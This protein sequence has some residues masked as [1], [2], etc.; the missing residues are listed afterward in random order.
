MRIDRVVVNSSPLITLFNS[1]HAE[2]LPGLFSEVHVPDA[3]WLEVAE[4]GHQDIA[5]Q[6]IRSAQWI[7]RLPPT[8]PDPLVMAWDA[9]LGETAVIS[10][11]RT[12]PDLRAIVD[13]DYA[14][15]CARALGVKTLGTCGVI[16]L[17]KHRHLIPCVK[18][19]LDA[20][21]ITGLWL[22]DG[23]VRTILTEAG[24]I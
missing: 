6:A 8:L 17:A 10:L 13:D 1:G 20:L 21:R 7:K 12:A 19:A 4:G 24:E 11:A 22:S 5:A 14:R 2:L 16:L 15:R 18:P 9:G 3:V 23:L